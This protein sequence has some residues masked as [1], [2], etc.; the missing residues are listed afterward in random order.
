M[1]INRTKEEWLELIERQRASGLTIETWCKKNGIN[2][3]GMSDAGS[4]LRKLGMLKPLPKRTNAD[5]LELVKLQRASGLT[6][7]AWCEDQGINLHTMAD[8]MSRL[9]KKGM[10]EPSPRRTYEYAAKRPK[11]E[12]VDVIKQQWTSG[13]TVKAWCAENGIKLPTFA[14]T[15]TRLRHSGHLKNFPKRTKDGTPTRTREEWLK[16]IK[17]QQSSGK[18]IMAWCKENGVK[19]P[20][21]SAA[22]K[23][24]G[25]RGLLTLAP[26]NNDTVKPPGESERA[27]PVTPEPKQSAVCEKKEQRQ[28]AA[29]QW[30]K[31]IQAA[32]VSEEPG[33]DQP[34]PEQSGEREIHVE[35]GKFSMALGAGFSQ[36]E[37]RRICEVLMSLC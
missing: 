6:V 1:G 7:E 20:A 28:P 4:R 8:R 9:R 18:K 12:W 3:S 17:E 11:E 33:R 29:G 23:R 36:A 10:L 16:L 24:L 5:W 25:K 27:D 30:V 19:Y 32:A 2:Y 15:I 13:L 37:F 35:I 31:V 26:G 21:M 34:V 14:G 22:I